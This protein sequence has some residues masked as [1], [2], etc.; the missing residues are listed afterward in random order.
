MVRFGGYT[1]DTNH[2]LWLGRAALSAE[3]NPPL[4]VLSENIQGWKRDS[5]SGML[6]SPWAVEE[7]EA[8]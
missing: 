1:L 5:E 6:C 2:R 4:L 8:C 7:D 3:S